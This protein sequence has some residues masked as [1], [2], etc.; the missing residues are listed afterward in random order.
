MK[1]QTILDDV[2]KKFSIVHDC[3]GSVGEH[4]E[5]CQGCIEIIIVEPE[6]LVTFLKEKLEQMERKNKYL[7]IE[8]TF[9]QLYRKDKIAYCIHDIEDNC[10]QNIEDIQKAV[11]YIVDKEVKKARESMRHYDKI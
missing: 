1:T 2:K 4:E 6:E 9:Y 8:H 10:F 7:S 11:E 3:T 5:Y